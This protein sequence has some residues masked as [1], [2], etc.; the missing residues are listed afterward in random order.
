VAKKLLLFFII[1]I[2][3]ISIS[4]CWDYGDINKADFPTTGAYDLHD[5]SQTAAARQVEEEQMLDL[6]VII[7]NISEEADL[8]FRIDKTS[9]LTIGN[10]RGQKPYSSPGL[11]SPGVAATIIFG[12]ELATRVGINDTLEALFRGAQ[13]PKTEDVAVAEGRAENILRIPVKDYPSMAEYLK[14]LLH[15]SENRAFIQDTSLYHMGISRNPGKNPIMPLLTIIDEKVEV[16]G[17]AIFN[18]GR[19]IG[20]ANLDET[21]N[22]MMLRG[23]KATGIIPFIIERDG[24]MLDKGSVDLKNSRKVKVVRNGDDFTF[25]IRIMLEGNLI[26]HQSTQLF[27]ENDDLRKMIE[28]QIENDIKEDCQKFIEKMQGEFQVDCIDI[29][30]YALAKWRKDLKNKVD[31]GFIENVNIKVEVKMKLKNVGELT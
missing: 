22:L 13:I 27:T 20:K 6:T 4:G 15:N 1:G 29:S 8:P 24:Q 2:Q 23:I 10:A 18:K 7:P 16:T 17:T 26:D 28:D 19:M 31:Q 12:E 30:K 5:E 3:L 9:G 14:A 21:R 25:Q 11:Y